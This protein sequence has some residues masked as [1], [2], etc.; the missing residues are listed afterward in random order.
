[1]AEIILIDGTLIHD[2]PSFYQ[3]INRVF[4]QG[5]DWELGES[6][7]ALNDLLYG[8]YGVLSGDKPATVRWRGTKQSREALGYACTKQYYLEK[9]VP[10]SPYNREFFKAKLEELEAGTGKTYFDIILEIISGHPNIV[11][12]TDERDTNGHRG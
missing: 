4:M 9:L 8:G 10:G 3:E 2:I 12:E 5:E 7:D 1:M 11:L 6:L